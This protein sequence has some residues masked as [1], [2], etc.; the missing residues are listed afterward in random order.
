MECNSDKYIRSRWGEEE[1]KDYTYMYIFYNLSWYIGFMRRCKKTDDSL[2][3]SLR[4]RMKSD[5]NEMIEMIEN[6]YDV[7]KVYTLL[8]IYL[9]VFST[10][11]LDTENVFLRVISARIVTREFGW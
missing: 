5:G 3:L 2:S 10:L 9:Y 8:L 1:K 4:F 7:C 6:T 11:F